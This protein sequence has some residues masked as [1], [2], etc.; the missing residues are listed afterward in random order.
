[1]GAKPFPTDHDLHCHSTLSRGTGDPRCTPG[2]MFRLAHKMGFKTISLADQMWDPAAPGAQGV[3][4]E[5]PPAK[6]LM[7]RHFASIEGIRALVGCE[8][9]YA[10]GSTV[11]VTKK[12][13]ALF[14]FIVIPPNH[15]HLNGF[16]RPDGIDTPEKMAQ[17]FVRRLDEL[18]RL[19]LPMEKVGVA[20]LTGSVLYPEGRV[21]DVIRCIAREDVRP[22]FLRYAERGAAIELNADAFGELR[23]HPDEILRLYRMAKECG[24]RFYCASDSHRIDGLGLIRR[25]L[26]EVAEMIGLSADDLYKIPQGGFD[27]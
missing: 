7:A 20:H 8:T 24:C 12:S 23:E 2:A 16:V 26:P 11:G 17:L 21:S 9:D 6:V 5:Q 27:R 10:G 4:L 19:D 18:S 22:I 14:D 3:Y 13:A 1:M 25:V 15:M